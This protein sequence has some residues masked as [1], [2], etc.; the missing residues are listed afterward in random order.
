MVTRFLCAETARLSITDCP[1]KRSSTPKD[2]TPWPY[3]LIPIKGYVVDWDAQKAI[4]DGMFLQLLKVASA[5][6]SQD[7]TYNTMS[8]S[9]GRLGILCSDNRALLQPPAN[10]TDL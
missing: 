10:P 9:G 8:G 3:M 4:W 7:I 5:L 1:V 6:R 2:L